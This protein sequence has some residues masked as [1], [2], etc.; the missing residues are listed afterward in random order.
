VGA[1]WKADR[2]DFVRCRPTVGYRILNGKF[3]CFPPQVNLKSSSTN[4]TD[5]SANLLV[6][7]AVPRMG[8]RDDGRPEM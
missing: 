2:P 3:T 1:E 6:G 5:I 8:W 7:S 4:Q